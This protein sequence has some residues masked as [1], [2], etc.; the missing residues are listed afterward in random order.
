MLIGCIETHVWHWIKYNSFSA[1]IVLAYITYTFWLLT[2]RGRTRMIFFNN[3]LLRQKVSN[4]LTLWYT[5]MFLFCISLQVQEVN[6]L[7]YTEAL[8]FW[9]EA[10]IFWCSKKVKRSDPEELLELK[11][12]VINS[13]G[14]SP[15]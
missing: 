1:L 11:R 10:L 15:I 5:W 4:I 13:G 9:S 12:E 3:G 14:V 6:H 8:I 2:K 7:W